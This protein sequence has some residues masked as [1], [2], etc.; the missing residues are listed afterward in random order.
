MNFLSIRPR[1]HS[2][3][4]SLSVHPPACSRRLL[5]HSLPLPMRL[6][7]K[8]PRSVP[9]APKWVPL[10]RA[11]PPVRPSLHSP[12][13]TQGAW[14]RSHSE[15]G[16]GAFGK[17]RMLGRGEAGQEGL[18]REPQLQRGSRACALPSAPTG[19]PVATCSLSLP[20]RSWRESKARRR[21]P[22]RSPM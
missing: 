4:T 16:I 9:V 3:L 6:Q 14:A 2:S 5:S 17:Q 11:E 13:Q 12:T 22:L 8:A 7:R 20:L 18:Q 15:E 19:P 10:S 1:F 21:S